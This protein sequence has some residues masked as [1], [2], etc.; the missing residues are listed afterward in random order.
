[1]PQANKSMERV[2]HIVVLNEV[3]N[4]AR[5]GKVQGLQWNAISIRQRGSTGSTRSRANT[6]KAI[7]ESELSAT[8][9]ISTKKREWPSCDTHI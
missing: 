5:P 2:Q 8:W 9:F 6:G 1:M 4:M 7:G 3:S